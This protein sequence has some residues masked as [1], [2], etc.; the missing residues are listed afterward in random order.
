MLRAPSRGARPCK[1]VCARRFACTFA[2]ILAIAGSACGRRDRSSPPRDAFTIYVLG[3]SVA[4]GHPYEPQVDF[5]RLV[6]L[7]FEGHVGGRPIQVENVA[8]KGKSASV[9]VDDAH[10][11]AKQPAE[12]GRAAA[13]VYIGNNEFVAYERKP[14]LRRQSPRALFDIPL[15]TAS[16]R[17]YVYARGRAALTEIITS[18]R[19][20][21]IEPIVSAVA[22]NTADWEPHRSVLENPL[23]AAAIRAALDAGEAALHAGDPGR[24]LSHFNAALDLEPRFAL[25]CKRAGDCCRALGEIDRA[26]TFYQRAIDCDGG[27]YRDTSEQN[28][29]VQEV[30]A[31]HQVAM[32]D[33]PAILAA[34]SA[35]GVVG[36]NFMWDNCH[37]TLDGYRR[38]AEGFAVALAAN[39][40]VR[41]RRQPSLDE[42]VQALGVDSSVTRQAYHMAGQYCYR[43]AILG[44]DGRARLDRSRQYLLH[45]ASL[46]AEDADITCSLATLA[47]I[48]NDAPRALAAWRRAWQLDA[49][50]ARE[51]SGHRYVMQLLESRGLESAVAELR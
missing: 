41:E 30:C 51:R 1:R 43:A 21:N 42:I 13:F 33:A 10:R 17:E 29:I 2:V 34:A 48:E 50:V 5:G 4:L 36:W 24:A 35:D 15:V 40:E 32:V 6:S 39:F 19:A 38:I 16:E 12:R 7:S 47:L 22:V 37:P 23:N 18:L 9:C 14:D 46:G 27:P 25:A 44:F 3:G 45:A 49:R 20:A 31:A 11:I 26:R 28:R 8:G